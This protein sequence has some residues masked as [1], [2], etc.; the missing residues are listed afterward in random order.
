MAGAYRTRA[1][2]ARRA[3]LEG[4]HL[5]MMRFVVFADKG[6]I[7]FAAHVNL[8]HA[9]QQ[10]MVNAAKAAG[11]SFPEL[12]PYASQDRI[13]FSVPITYRQADSG[14]PEWHIGADIPEA[15]VDACGERVVPIALDVTMAI[16]P[17]MTMAISSGEFP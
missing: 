12:E 5:E 6:A 17:I 3:L 2:A 9:D 4:A 8:K 7:R 13:L 15:T 10:F 1:D 14:E 16:M 11:R